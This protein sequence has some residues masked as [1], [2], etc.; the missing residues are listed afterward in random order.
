[1]AGKV[2]ATPNGRP[3][4]GPKNSPLPGGEVL[5][6]CSCDVPSGTV[7]L[8]LS[9]YPD[10]ASAREGYEFDAQAAYQNGNGMRFTG[11]PASGSRRPYPTGYSG[12][13]AGLRYG[14]DVPAMH[15]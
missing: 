3:I 5:R 11:T 9:I 2:G 8:E 14:V 7:G 15:T 6:S 12:R 10:T 13:P 1:M 4:P